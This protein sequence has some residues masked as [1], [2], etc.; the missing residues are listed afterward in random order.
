M[1]Y[2][3]LLD[4]CRQ[5]CFDARSVVYLQELIKNHKRFQTETQIAIIQVR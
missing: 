3:R 1:Y 5:D 4:Q 2:E